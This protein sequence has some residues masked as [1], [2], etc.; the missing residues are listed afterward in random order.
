MFWWVTNA[1]QREMAVALLRPENNSRTCRVADW[2]FS[3]VTATDTGCDSV[4][5]ST[6]EQK[7]A[8]S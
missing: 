8:Q 7:V 5:H 1:L 3:C 4:E 6:S 2:H